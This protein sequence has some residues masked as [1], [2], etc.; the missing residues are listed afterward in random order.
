VPGTPFARLVARPKFPHWRNFGFR[1]SRPAVGDLFAG[2]GGAAPS[3][4]L[5]FGYGAR[6]AAG[7]AIVAAAFWA[8]GHFLVEGWPRLGLALVGLLGLGLFLQA[9][10]DKWKGRRNP[11]YIGLGLLIAAGPWIISLHDFSVGYRW[12]WP[13]VWWIVIPGLIGLALLRRGW[14]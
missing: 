9:I 6:A 4:N 1:R 10:E 13:S 3:P 12:E 8:N 7:L 2:V 5:R 11:V 14:K